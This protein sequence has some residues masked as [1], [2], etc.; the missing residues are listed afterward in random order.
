[1]PVL[2]GLSRTVVIVGLLVAMVENAGGT[3]DESRQ[4]EAD[5]TPAA[6]SD[7][8]Q[9]L[10]N[11]FPHVPGSRWVYR[12]SGSWYAEPAELAL[13][14]RGREY[15]PRLG[16]EAVVIDETHPG[17]T[18]T[19]PRDVLPVL[20]YPRGDYLVR[21]TNHVYSDDERTM[22]MQTGTL[23]EAAAPVLPLDPATPRTD[24]HTVQAGEW[25]EMSQLDT[26]YRFRSEPDPVVVPA[27]T[28]PGCLHAETRI[29]RVSG[30]GFLYAEWYAPGTGLVRMRTTDLTS[31]EVVEQKDLVEYLPAN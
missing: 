16:L 9:R 5:A 11:L 31:G 28:Y 19:A 20:Y 3:D 18:P 2:L 8:W 4:P 6:A 17:V 10:S 30:R 1:M 29:R 24:W 23:G 26:E 14:V 21:N 7:V 25:G 27:G 12:L 13:Q 15:V 22:L